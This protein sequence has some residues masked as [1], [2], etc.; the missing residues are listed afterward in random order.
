MPTLPSAA[1]LVGTRLPELTFRFREG[2]AWRDRTTSELFGGKRVVAFGLPGAF[3]PTCSSAH[4]PRYDE[5]AD[6]FTARGVDSLMVI[7]VND[8]FVM[9][10]WERD[11]GTSRVTYLPDGNGALTA[12]LGLLVDKS[13][14]A[15][16]KRSWRYAMVV[17]DGVIERAFVEPDQ[18]GDPFEVSDADS[19]LK[20]LDAD[21]AP[22]DVVLVGREGCSFCVSARSML[23]EAGLSFEEIAASPRR[24]RAL[25]GRTSTPQIFV[26]GRHIGGSEELA[27]WLIAR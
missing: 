11:Q 9:E 21:A 13:N 4:V 24:L 2:A 17:N 15:F 7:S 27:A 5:L 16:G 10:A 23:A 12:A 22:V 19:V 8:P 6:E 1:D 25:T 3:T 26:N 20:A 14:L 18:A